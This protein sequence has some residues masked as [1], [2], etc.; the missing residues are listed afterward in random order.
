MVLDRSER[1]PQ[2]CSLIEY[3]HIRGIAVSGFVRLVALLPE[4]LAAADD[5]VDSR[6]FAGADLSQRECNCCISIQRKWT[7]G[8]QGV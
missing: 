6:F 1:R 4:L 3:A 2:G 5:R 7:F 8:L